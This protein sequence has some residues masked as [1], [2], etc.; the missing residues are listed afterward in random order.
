MFNDNFVVTQ[1]GDLKLY[2]TA[3]RRT[4]NLSKKDF[5]VAL[6]FVPGEGF[7]RSFFSEQECSYWGFAEIDLIGFYKIIELKGKGIDPESAG[8]KTISL[9]IKK[10]LSNPLQYTVFGLMEGLKMFFWEST[11]IGF[12][13]YPDPLVR[14]FSY[15]SFKNALRLFIFMLTFISFF[16]L[17][18][19]SW[20]KRQT[21]LEN[22][23]SSREILLLFM[24]LLIFQFIGIHCLF[25]TVTRYSLPIAPL[26]LIVIAFFL[27]KVR[28]KNK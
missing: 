16:Y 27:Q 15:K 20:K 1:R 9:A 6:A 4:E 25:N 7:C 21:M 23:G 2:G 8:K 24:L 14:I 3:V 13:S 5:L 17:L 28:L 22:N 12:V 19:Y 10:A 11:A 18:G 26:Y